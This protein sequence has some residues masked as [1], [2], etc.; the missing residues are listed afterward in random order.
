MTIPPFP[1]GIDDASKLRIAAL[2][3]RYN[4]LAVRSQMMGEKVGKMAVEHAEI[5]KESKEIENELRTLLKI[6]KRRIFPP[7]WFLIGLGM[8][9]AFSI[10]LWST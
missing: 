2:Y 3:A 1:P 10:H 7:W 4:E 6:P 5:R 8:L 9:I